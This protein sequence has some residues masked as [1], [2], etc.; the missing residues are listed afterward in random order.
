MAYNRKA[1][2]KTLYVRQ[3]L[4]Q[5]TDADHGLTMRQLIERLEALGIEAE[6]KSVY[7]D[8]NI[9]R[10]FGVDIQTFQRNPVEYA[11]VRRD[12]ELSEL[13]LLIDAVASC[14]FLTKRQSS[15]LIANL[16]TFASDHQRGLLDRR[17][18]VDGRITS[19]SDSVF[20][21]VDDI[22]R[23]LR[24]RKKIEFAY[25]RY[26]VDGQR[27]PTRGGEPHVVTPV[28]IAYS[29][30]FYYLTAWNDKHENMTE[31]RID[32]MD[33][34]RVTELRATRNDEIAHHTYDKNEHEYFGRFSG[35]PIT[36]MLHVS[37]DKVEIVLD[38]FGSGA[39]ISQVD[40]S[41]ARATVK[42][43]KSEQ[44][45]GWIAGL[46]GTVTIAGPDRLRKEYREYLQ[47]L[48]GE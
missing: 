31:F 20:G 1:K 13:M 10:E 17:I 30:G 35:E 19:K 5:E 9:L 22:H 43:R 26:N 2:L 23:A 27:C 28:S 36:A 18:H 33:K 12:F 41:A 3:I 21:Y 8:I 16:K 25:C 45:F 44:F 14:R 15:S 32:R 47:S 42:V 38:R 7:R 4:E 34:L 48:L 37:D 6:R 24:E 40:A 46:G 29:D 39:Q 11:I